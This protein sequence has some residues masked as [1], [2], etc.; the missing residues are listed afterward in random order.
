VIDTGN[1]QGNLASRD[2]VIDVLG[3]TE[4]DFKP[5]TGREKDGGLT[6]SGELLIPEGAVNITW[7]HSN[8]AKV[9]RNMRFLVVSK[10]PCDLVIGS[11][12]I[13]KHKLLLPPNFMSGTPD[14][15]QQLSR[16]EGMLHK[17]FLISSQSKGYKKFLVTLQYVKS[18]GLAAFSSRPSS[19]A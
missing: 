1:Q 13:N 14:D 10:A 17:M 15:S 5:L 18:C 11:Q 7:H 9:F 19:L 16:L 4:S 3:Y 6:A 12:S 8:S 2:F